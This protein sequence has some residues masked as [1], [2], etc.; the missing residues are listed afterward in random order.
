MY[1]FT[2]HLDLIKSCLSQLEEGKAGG[3][4]VGGIRPGIGV[5]L[6]G[7]GGG[8]GVFFFFLLILL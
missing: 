6:G 1:N 3:G 7:G 5:R 8:G 2:S 4:R